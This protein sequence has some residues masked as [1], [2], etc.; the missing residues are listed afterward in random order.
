MSK[1]KDNLGVALVAEIV[2]Q[3]SSSGLSNSDF[4]VADI[5]RLAAE[6]KAM[7]SMVIS[8]DLSEDQA[9]LHRELRF[10]AFEMRLLAIKGVDE[11][12]LGRILD[13]VGKVIRRFYGV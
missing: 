5:Q 3:L 1:I 9:V 4:E 7:H 8:G 12:A 2:V 6:L 11:I 13:G 10:N